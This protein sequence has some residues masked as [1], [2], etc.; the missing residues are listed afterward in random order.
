MGNVS[1]LRVDGFKWLEENDPLRFNESFIKNFDE[2]SDKGYISE[3]DIEYPK[4][5][6][7]L[8]SDLSF[9]PVQKKKKA[10]LLA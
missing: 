6:N 1:K 9:L 10:M 3:V 4:K 2:N 5:L 7:K 8:H